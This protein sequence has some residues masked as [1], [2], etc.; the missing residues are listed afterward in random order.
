MADYKDLIIRELDT[1]RKADLAERRIFQAKAYQ[2]VINGLKEMNEP[3]SSFES[4]KDLP[5]VGEK[6]KE[7]IKEILE[8]GSLASAA[9]ARDRLALDSMEM[10]EGVHGIGPVKAK[11]LI[12]K[13]GIKTIE[14]LRKKL[15]EKP[16]LLNDIQKMGL[17]YY[18][19]SQL[20]IPRE[21]MAGLESLLLSAFPDEFRGEITGSYRRGAAD[22]GDIDLLLTVS[23]DVPESQKAAM[24]RNVLHLLRDDGILV[25]TL[26]EGPKK[27]MGYIRLDPGDPK[28]HA[29]RLDIV[30]TPESEFPYAILY[31]TGSQKFNVAFRKY[32]LQKGYSLNEHAMTPL[33]EAKAPEPGQIRTE[34]DIFTFLGLEYVP[35]TER[36]D[37]KNIRPLKSGG[38]RRE[39]SQSKSRG[40]K[41]RGE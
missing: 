2:K 33:G 34:K 32:A 5:G 26:A 40:K 38:K 14:Q 4:V 24:F 35:P 3:I 8:T 11:D 18:E 23:D 36:V 19:D 12:E 9:R 37:E 1:L 29:R 10:L 27:F 39:R 17:K 6:I 28:G 25:D 30:I 21:E 31:F 22:S 15:E 20:R 16:D 13:H 7:K 41:K